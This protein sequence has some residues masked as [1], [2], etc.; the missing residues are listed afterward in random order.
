M[1]S[2]VAP[3]F[4][5]A[6]MR[7]ARQLGAREEGKRQGAY[8]GLGRPPSRNPE[9]LLDQPRHQHFAQPL[10]AA[11]HQSHHDPTERVRRAQLGRHLRLRLLD[12]T[13]AQM[14]ERPDVRCGSR[15]VIHV[16]RPKGGEQLV[17]LSDDAQGGGGGRGELTNFGRDSAFGGKAGFA[18]GWVGG[19]GGEDGGLDV[20]RERASERSVKRHADTK[21]GGERDALPSSQS[22]APTRP[23]VNP[24][25]SPWAGP[26]RQPSSPPRPPS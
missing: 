23:V 3:A 22:T 10:M 7:V 14:V 25:P 12:Q 1:F 20:L 11:R 2:G 19:D 8:L 21:T 9:A 17:E 4:E 18:E 24:R 6:R 5:T 15:F 13:L 16:R 26:S